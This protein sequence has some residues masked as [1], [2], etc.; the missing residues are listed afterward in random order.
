MKCAIVNSYSSV[1][2][3]FHP[4]FK[5]LFPS[6]CRHGVC[7]DAIWAADEAGKGRTAWSW[8]TAKLQLLE[9]GAMVGRHSCLLYHYYDNESQLVPTVTRTLHACCFIKHSASYST[10]SS[11]PHIF[12]SLKLFKLCCTWNKDSVKWSHQSSQMPV[13]SGLPSGCAWIQRLSLKVHVSERAQLLC[14]LRN[15]FGECHL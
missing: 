12:L 6:E 15:D 8:S 13:T 7:W 11:L 9:R 2:Y 10:L 5:S 3:Y 4:P 1:P 14:R